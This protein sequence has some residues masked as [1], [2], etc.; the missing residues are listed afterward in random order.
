MTSFFF[1][2]R[3]RPVIVAKNDCGRGDGTR[4]DGEGVLGDGSGS[5]GCG[6]GDAGDIGRSGICSV[7]CSCPVPGACACG[8]SDSGGG[9]DEEGDGCARGDAGESSGESGW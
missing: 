6:G 9:G 4:N 5:V 2:R 8:V 1:R 3:W 7:K